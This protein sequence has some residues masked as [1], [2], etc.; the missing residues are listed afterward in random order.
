M[1]WEIWLWL[2]SVTAQSHALRR[3]ISLASLVGTSAGT[4]G[5]AVSFVEIQISLWQIWGTLRH[6]RTVCSLPRY[7]DRKLPSAV[8]PLIL[9][10]IRRLPK[11]SFL[12]PP[13]SMGPEFYFLH[14]NAPC[15]ATVMALRSTLSDGCSGDSTE[16]TEPCLPVLALQMVIFGCLLCMH[17]ED[18]PISAAAHPHPNH[19]HF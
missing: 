14:G 16:Y 19:L 3:A 18:K 13:P 8:S 17:L 5:I 2:S 10:P 6:C 4:A 12:H 15:Y 11:F 9:D 1:R 7:P